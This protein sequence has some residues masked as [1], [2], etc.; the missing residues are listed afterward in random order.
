MVQNMKTN[1]INCW[2]EYGT[3]II[4]EH[5]NGTPTLLG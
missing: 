2:E 1:N 5:V 3:T 4:G